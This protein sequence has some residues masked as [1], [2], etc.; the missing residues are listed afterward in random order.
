MEA[1][2]LGS[3][4]M[5]APSLA[6]FGA[7]G[8]EGIRGLRPALHLQRRRAI[9]TGHRRARSAQ[10]LLEKLEPKGIKGL[11]YWDNGFKS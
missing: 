6:K 1:L 4:Q 2:Q 9:C 11:A 8:R 5:L 3:V 7:A 10:S